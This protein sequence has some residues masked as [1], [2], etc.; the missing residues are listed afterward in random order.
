MPLEGPLLAAGR[1]AGGSGLLKLSM[2]TTFSLGP[3]PPVATPVLLLPK[4]VS[5]RY[6]QRGLVY[7]PLLSRIQQK[8]QC[9]RAC[10]LHQRSTL[11]VLGH[12]RVCGKCVICE[13]MCASRP[14]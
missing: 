9:V 13:G 6:K 3:G 5:M 10:W 14:T 11:D 7:K 8:S 1:A 12:V 2:I 4:P